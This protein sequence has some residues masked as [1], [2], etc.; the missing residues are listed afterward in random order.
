MDNAEPSASLRHLLPLPSGL[1][2]P[3]DLDMALTLGGSA[4][5]EL[6]GL[7]DQDRM[8]APL[9]GVQAEKSLAG[10]STV[11]TYNTDE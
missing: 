5:A 10:T 3:P 11:R 9:G 7:P 2:L 6:D 8:V 1:L 4:P